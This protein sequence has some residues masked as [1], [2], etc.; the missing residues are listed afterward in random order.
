MGD[1]Y[2]KHMGKYPVNV[3]YAFLRVQK[4]SET[5]TNAVINAQYIIF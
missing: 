5:F 2:L 3:T 4:I 1:A